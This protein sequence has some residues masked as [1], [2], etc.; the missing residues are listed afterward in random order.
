MTMSKMP[1]RGGCFNYY[2]L[3]PMGGTM[4]TL[5]VWKWTPLTPSLPIDPLLCLCYSLRVSH[6]LVIN[7]IFKSI[8]GESSFAGLPCVFVRLTACN[9]RCSWCDTTYSFNE[10]S[11]MKVSEVIVRVLEYDCPL[12]E[13]TGGEPLLQPN[14][15]PLMTKLCDLGKQVLLETSGSVDVSRV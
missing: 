13:I 7:E 12:V 4:S 9:L 6:T 15:F 2:S 3:Y 10:G 11:P 5:S 1:F 14:V 8:Q